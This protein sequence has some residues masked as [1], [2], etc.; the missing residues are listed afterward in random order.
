MNIE[1]M[2]LSRKDCS[3]IISCNFGTEHDHGI[4]DQTNDQVNM[5]FGINESAQSGFGF[6]S[7]MLKFNEKS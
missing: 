1:E 7:T 2:D 4:Q 3:K 5:I 6:N